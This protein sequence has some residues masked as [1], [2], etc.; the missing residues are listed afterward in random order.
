MEFISLNEL[1][2]KFIPIW[3]DVDKL[4]KKKKIICFMLCNHFS[5]CLCEQHLEIVAQCIVLQMLRAMSEAEE[6]RV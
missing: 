5:H 6:K 1:E 3:E 2:L 4:K